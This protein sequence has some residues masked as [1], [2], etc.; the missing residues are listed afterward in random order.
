MLSY[1]DFAKKLVDSGATR[2]L[3]SVHADNPELGDFLVCDKG[4]W[5]QTI[6]GIKNIKKVGIDNLRFSVVANKYNYERFPEI[7]DFL[8]QFNAVGY[9]MG[10][11]IPDGYAY[12]RKD[13]VPRMSEAVPYL[14]RA[15]D[16]VLA[17][18]SEAWMY[19]IPYCLM[20]GYEHVVAELGITDT[21]LRGPDFEASIQNNR[22]KYRTKGEGCKDCRY[23]PVCIGVWKRYVEMLGFDEFKPVAGEKVMSSNDIMKQHYKL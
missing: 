23:D 10:F 17:A 16:K 8:L 20:Q 18:G 19:S 11:V 6:Q 22:R 15:I 3:I 5:N 2:F 13:L 21:I 12:M 9:H 7:I 14:K 1:M 4:A